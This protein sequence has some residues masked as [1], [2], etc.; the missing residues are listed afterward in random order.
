LSG[1]DAGAGPV[2]RPPVSVMYISPP[3]FSSL[4]TSMPNFFA[5][6]K[7]CCSGARTFG[8]SAWCHFGPLSVTSPAGIGAN[9]TDALSH[10]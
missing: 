9:A 6:S 1:A 8:T 4:N 3:V 7:L 2:A 5:F 10:A